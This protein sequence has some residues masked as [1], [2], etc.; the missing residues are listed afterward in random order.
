MRYGENP[1]KTQTSI[2]SFANGLLHVSSETV[3]R[4]SPSTVSRD[5]DAAIRIIRD[6]KDRPTVALK[7]HGSMWHYRF[8]D[9][10]TAW[11]YA[12]ESDPASIFDGIVVSIVE[13]DAAT[14]QK[15][16]GVF[17]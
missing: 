8:D 16:H 15:M 5:A 13:V 1:N 17:L 12:Y 4:V 6:F 2:K 10:E 9:I 14:A 3:E 7:T 11:D